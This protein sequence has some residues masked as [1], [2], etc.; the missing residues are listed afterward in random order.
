M[1]YY[2]K[3]LFLVQM[4]IHRRLPQCLKIMQR[5]VVL[6]SMEYTGTHFHPPI[7]RSQKMR[8]CK[9]HTILLSPWDSV[10]FW[11]HFHWP[12]LVMWY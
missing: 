11:S 12:D 6:F 8:K 3:K 7:K 5:F 4:K 1:A 2:N 9:S 10:T